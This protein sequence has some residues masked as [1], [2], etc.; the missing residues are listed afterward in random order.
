MRIVHSDDLATALA[1]ARIAVEAGEVV[2][3]PTDTVYGIGADPFSYD[4]VSALLAAKSR[5]RAMPPPVLVAG[6]EQAETLVAKFPDSA[7][8]LMNA[9]WPGALTII[10][11]ARES[12]G[13]DLGETFG[14]VGLRMPDD[15]VTLAFLEQ[16]GPL[17]VTSA[18]KTG[19]MPATTICQAVDQLGQA[20]SV[21]V[22]HG[23]SPGGVPS[24]IV[25]WNG[26]DDTYEIL[27]QGAITLHQLS[28]VVRVKGEA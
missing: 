1:E 6:I 4:A 13:W 23:Q 11:P 21:Y 9:F 18:N 28:S 5:T 10:L 12:L 16:V 15:D 3:L 2:C 8:D 22:D 26:D 14:T 17:A 20:V 27:R 25:R 24:T 19:Q 7:R